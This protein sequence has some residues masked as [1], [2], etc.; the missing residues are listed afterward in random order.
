MF[1]KSLISWARP[2]LVAL[3]LKNTSCSNLRS[4]ALDWKVSSLGCS[5]GENLAESP[6]P[7]GE[8]EDH[9]QEAGL[10]LK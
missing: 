2:Q 6:P 3:D 5:P 9:S 10:S 4:S 7:V 1:S 8:C